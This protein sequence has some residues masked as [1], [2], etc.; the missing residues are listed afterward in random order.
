V[1]VCHIVQNFL[2]QL[3]PPYEYTR[4]LAAA[5][6]SVDVFAFR[7]PNEPEEEIIEG[8]NVHRV[9]TQDHSVFTAR[10]AFRFIPAVLRAL[11]GR[12]Y[13]IA[14]VHAFR[15]CSLLRMLAG[16]YARIWMMNI[17]S[18]NVTSGRYKAKI[19][20]RVTGIESLVFD[21]VLVHTAEIARRILIPGR[22]FHLLPCGADFEKF[23]PGNNQELRSKLKI[24][25]E[26][27][28]VGFSSSLTSLRNPQQVIR[29]FALATTHRPDLNLLVIGDGPMLSELR[30]LAEE[31]GVST[32]THFT[33]YVPYGEVH[34][35]V[36]TALEDGRIP[37]L[38]PTHDRYQ[39][40]WK[41]SLHSGW[42]E[43][44]VGGR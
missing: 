3:S 14:H 32:R 16:P 39:N 37:R 38:W 27:P 11:E 34:K 10:T 25:P 18:G 30:K 1:K 12:R 20:D 31:L 15:G 17:R 22:A 40:A 9:I 29:A 33:G 42:G 21:E 43:W 36:V 8:V 24:P 2:T 26:A 28:V 35:A 5:G 4:K 44:V 6:V 23:V 41:C 13:D 7:H 19:L